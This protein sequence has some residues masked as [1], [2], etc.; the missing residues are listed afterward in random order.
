[1]GK[2][3]A[4]GRGPGRVIRLS[5]RFG[6]LVVRLKAHDPDQKREERKH[7]PQ[8]HPQSRLHIIRDPEDNVIEIYAEY[9]CV[10]PN[11]RE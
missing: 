5:G 3:F 4:R 1:L 7:E 9:L 2:H 6:D 8:G 11:W 10:A